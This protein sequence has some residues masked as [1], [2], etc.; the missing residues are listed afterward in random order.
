[1]FEGILHD[2][3]GARFRAPFGAAPCGA[4]IRLSLL[5]PQREIRA[6]LRLWVQGGER[7][8]EGRRAGD[9][10]EFMF[11]AGETGLIWYYFLL[12]TP[13]GPRYYGGRSGVGAVYDYPP[14]SY[15]ITVY[16]PKFETPAWF[17]EGIAYQV[18]LDRFHRH[19]ARGG[20]D[21][22]AYHSALGRSIYR[23]EDW[24][25][26][27]LYG[28]L[29]GKK[30]YDPCDFYGGDIQGLIDK[31][32]YLKELGVTCIY[33]NPIFESPSNH[34][35]NTS[36]YLRVDPVL[37]GEDDLRTLVAEAKA[38]GMRIILDGVFSHTGDDSVY[39]NR[40]GRYPGRGA[41]Q[42]QD[43]PY[44]EWYDFRAW[45]D[46]YRAWWGFPTL[47]EVEEMTP[48]YMAFVGEVID[49]YAALGLT[50]WRLDVADELPDAFIAFL[51]ERVKANDPEG[52]LLGEVWDDA[53]NKEG[54]GARRKY[55]DGHALDSVMNYP[56][57]DA[58]ADFFLY[59]TDAE[60]LLARLFALREN[61]PKPFYDA[62]LNLL[63]SHDTPRIA[64]VL[65]GAPHRDALTREEQA[66]FR[67]G[68]DAASRGKARLALAQTL[69]FAHPGVPCTYYGDEIGMF[70]MADPFCR[71]P[72]P[73]GEEDGVQL[74][75]YK[76]IAAARRDSPA[77][78]RGAC[79]FAAFS[80]DV[81]AI[82]RTEGSESALAIVNR[83]EH[84]E[85]VSVT[86][87]DFRRGP[88]G[89]KLFLARAYSGVTTDIRVEKRDGAL[90]LVLPP[91]SGTLLISEKDV[92]TRETM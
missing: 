24:N 28:P 50:S 83:S 30:D 53:S 67:L 49:R 63:G 86:E 52:L 91:L 74:A 62:C 81:F 43:S 29:P 4:E 64:T 25:E 89:D 14:P 11:R 39:F 2:S 12:E 69:L 72:Y 71:A 33:L 17:R 56:L 31:L 9:Y 61:Y 66:R 44:R 5:V 18:F 82:L 55:V 32:P 85:R 87:E 20:L 8:L 47:P 45:P 23:H 19:G 57:R 65:G 76:R 84:A 34:R 35:Y 80:K 60:G 22:T 40:Y 68:P 77:L 92:E 54:F 7:I 37:G 13:A 51:R 1:M 41:Y 38:A 88:D 73:W 46:S 78:A 42:S 6:R 59:R 48:S 3:I 10:Y 21:R 16:D 79:G 36:N 70:G 90:H 26:E 75:H 15:Q 58:L 27:V